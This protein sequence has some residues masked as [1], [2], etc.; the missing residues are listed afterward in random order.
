MLL[1]AVL[2]ITGATAHQPQIPAI[3][4]GDY[5]AGGARLTASCATD[6]PSFTLVEGP[7]ANHT[8]KVRLAN[9]PPTCGHVADLKTPCASAGS[10]GVPAP[11]PVLLQL[12]I[13]VG[14]VERGRRASRCQLRCGCEH[15]RG[16]AVLRALHQMPDGIQ[17]IPE[18]APH[19]CGHIAAATIG[20]DPDAGPPIRVLR[21]FVSAAIA[22]AAGIERARRHKRSA[23]T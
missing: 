10:F 12:C 14:R 15:A 13:H 19:R 17:R 4:F 6:E 11:T 20:C 2:F 16:S 1:R 18:Y 8:V 9:V 22:G 5:A 3:S 7:D 21:A 23:E